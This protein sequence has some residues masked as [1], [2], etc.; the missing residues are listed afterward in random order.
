LIDFLLKRLK[1]P[2]SKNGGRNP[3]KVDTASHRKKTLQ[4]DAPRA[5][6]MT[7]KK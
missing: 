2:F 3:A 5:A 4:Q 6:A 1:W 7:I